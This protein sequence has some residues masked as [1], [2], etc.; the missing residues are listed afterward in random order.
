MEDPK[1]SHTL[2]TKALCCYRCSLQ[3]CEKENVAPHFILYGPLSIYSMDFA[4][5]RASHE[6]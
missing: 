5:L 1:T 2:I 6:K 3:K 4:G